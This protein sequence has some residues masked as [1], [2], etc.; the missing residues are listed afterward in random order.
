MRKWTRVAI[1]VA[2]LCVA[3][4]AA[5]QDSP[6]A[7][8]KNPVTRLDNITAL[9]CTFPVSSIGSWGKDDA[10]PTARVRAAGG[11]V[12]TVKVEKLDPPGATGEITAPTRAEAIVQQYGWNMHIME[13]SRSGRMLMLTVFGR[14][15]TGNKLK[16]VYTR[17]DYLPVD[18]PGFISE[19]EAAQYYGDCEVTR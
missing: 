19:P 13:P 9:T 8:N 1:A 17:T 3:A 10:P 2:S 16:A 18:L 7:E 4:V 14:V 5:A 11:P 6:A 12:L 15:S